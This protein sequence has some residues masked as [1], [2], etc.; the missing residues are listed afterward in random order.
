MTTQPEQILE[1]NLVTQLIALGY[2]KVAVTNE[3]ELL[4]NLKSQLEKH[5]KVQLSRRILSKFSITLTREL[6]L[7]VLK[8]YEIECL[9]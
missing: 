1:N 8:Y 9:M 7:N 3:S 2:K 5:N 6:F 4:S